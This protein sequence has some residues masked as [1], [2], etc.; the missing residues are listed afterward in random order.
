MSKK[1]FDE[2]VQEL[3]EAKRD[4]I[5]ASLGW[6]FNIACE[7]AEGILGDDPELDD[8]IRE[9]LKSDAPNEYLASKI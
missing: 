8:Y 3:K 5:D 6:D 9:E 1:L 7:L 2:T 4:N